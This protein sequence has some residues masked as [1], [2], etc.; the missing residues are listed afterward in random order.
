MLLRASLF[1]VAV[2]S[3]ACPPDGTRLRS[4][5]ECRCRFAISHGFT[6]DPPFDGQ[7]VFL[8][9]A[10]GYN[11]TELEETIGYLGPSIVAWYDLCKDAPKR[12][13]EEAEKRRKRDADR[14]ER[15]K[16]KALAANLKADCESARVDRSALLQRNAQKW[17]WQTKEVASEWMEE[18]PCG[19]PFSVDTD[20]YDLHIHPCTELAC[21]RLGSPFGDCTVPVSVPDFGITLGPRSVECVNKLKLKV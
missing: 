14:V 13:E 5:S 11:G 1:F 16:A 15:W 12:A 6:D 20:D 2:T 3:L 10:D 19:R 8:H 17:F 7:Y 9:F 18:C 21:L 4:V